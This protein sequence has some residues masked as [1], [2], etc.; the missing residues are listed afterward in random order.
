MTAVGVTAV[1]GNGADG[2]GAGDNIYNT[3]YQIGTVTIYD[4]IDKVDASSIKNFASVVYM[5]DETDVTAKPTI[6]SLLPTA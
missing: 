5:H 4:D 1:G 6:P 2:I 3:T